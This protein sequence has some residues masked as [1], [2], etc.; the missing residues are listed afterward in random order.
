MKYGLVLLILFASIMGEA[1][2][3]NA[4]KAPT[5]PET[6]TAK[7]TKVDTNPKV[8]PQAK[9]ENTSG[10]DNKSAGATPLQPGLPA[11]V[12]IEGIPTASSSLPAVVKIEGIPTASDGFLSSAVATI[13]AAIIGGIIALVTAILAARSEVNRK[14]KEQQLERNKLAADMKKFRAEMDFKMNRAGADDLRSTAEIAIQCAKADVELKR[15]G[16]DKIVSDTSTYI[17]ATRLVHNFQIAEAKLIDSYSGYLLNDQK[18]QRVFGL[19]ALAICLGPQMIRTLSAIIS[20]ETLEDLASLDD[21]D[22]KAIANDLLR[23]RAGRKSPQSG[24][25][26]KDRP[27]LI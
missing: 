19:V 25:S 14:E 1:A 7:P 8:A 18:Q 9:S 20:K 16:L 23:E 24:N 5:I 6:K 10:S 21:T 12:R 4:S 22:I 3:Q 11:V 27:L 2:A 17:D 13:I 26:D 15:F